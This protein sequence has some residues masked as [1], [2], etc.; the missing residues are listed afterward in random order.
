MSSEIHRIAQ[1]F[2]INP[3]YEDEEIDYLFSLIEGEHHEGTMNQYKL[4]KMLWDAILKHS[5]R[6]KREKPEL[7]QKI[8][9]IREFTIEEGFKAP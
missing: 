4:P 2:F 3:F 6:I 8:S 1:G 7:Q 5:E 9:K